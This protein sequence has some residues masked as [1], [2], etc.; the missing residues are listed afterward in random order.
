MNIDMKS[1]RVLERGDALLP[2]RAKDTHKGDYGRLMIIGGSVG[3]TGAPAMCAKAALRA[4]AGL[5]YMGVPEDIYAIECAKTDE[6]MPFPLPSDADGKISSRA[7]PALLDRLSRCDA[8]VLG[9]GLGRVEEQ[10]ELVRGILEGYSGKLLLDADG[11]YAASGD[12]S[13]IDGASCWVVITP[14]AGEFER[15]AGILPDEPARDASEFSKS[16]GCVTVLKGPETAIAFPDAEVIVSRLGNPGM[17]TGGTG[18][19]LAGIIG[20]LMGQLPLK[21]AVLAGVYIHG[22]AGDACAEAFGEYSMLPGDIIE[23]IPEVMKKLTK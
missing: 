2:A 20:G 18:D 22:A 7:L 13:M 8:C 9:P 17:A 4:G 23:M 5:V 19:V 6:A 11:L 15:L 14:H 1:V 21:K 10:T 16:F 12:L 3:Y